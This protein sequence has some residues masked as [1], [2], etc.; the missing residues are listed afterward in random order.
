M[1]RVRHDAPPSVQG[2]D[3]RPEHPGCPGRQVRQTEDCI[4]AD[5]VASSYQGGEKSICVRRRSCRLAILF[6]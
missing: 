6:G 5:V 3:F 4:V 1:R 2:G